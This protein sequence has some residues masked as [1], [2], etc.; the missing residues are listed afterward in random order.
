MDVVRHAHSK[1]EILGGRVQFKGLLTRGRG[2]AGFAT[3]VLSD[4]VADPKSE[5]L[6]RVEE[7]ASDVYPP[8]RDHYK[9]TGK[10]LP[11]ETRKAL[12]SRSTW[13]AERFKLSEGLLTWL[14]GN[15]ERES[16]IEAMKSLDAVLEL[17]I[18]VARE[19]LTQN[20]VLEN[21]TSDVYDQF[22]LHYLALDRYVIVSEDS[23]LRKRTSC[24]SQADRIMSFEQFLQRCAA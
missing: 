8:W 14:G 11:D 2:R 12:E 21:H 16:V 10:R 24:S 6:R 22:Q 18:F 13:E 20:Y 4:L 1:E 7:F 15:A 9:S 23:N 3:S 19:F 17:S 5:W